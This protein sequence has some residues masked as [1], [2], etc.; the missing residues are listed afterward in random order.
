MREIGD[1][2]FVHHEL[3]FAASNAGNSS[4]NRLLAFEPAMGRWLKPTSP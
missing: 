4:A 3:S 2:H 1:D